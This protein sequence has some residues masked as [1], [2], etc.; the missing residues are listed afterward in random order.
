MRRL[1]EQVNC[2]TEVPQSMLRHAPCTPAVAL[3][4]HE[5][6][7]SMNT[8]DFVR[9][10]QEIGEVCPTGGLGINSPYEGF[11]GSLGF[12]SGTRAALVLAALYKCAG[13]VP[14]LVWHLQDCPCHMPGAPAVRILPTLHMPAALTMPCRRTST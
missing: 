1:A 9:A 11:M 7:H 5:A 4:R 13:K 8:L 3:D 10:T 14:A 2:A 12:Y 6:S